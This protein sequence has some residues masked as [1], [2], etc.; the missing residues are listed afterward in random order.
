MAIGPLEILLG[1]V[2]LKRCVFLLTIV[3]AIMAIVCV[4]NGGWHGVDG[5]NPAEWILIIFSMPWF[6]LLALMPFVP[7][8]DAGYF[9]GIIWF[10]IVPLI[11]NSLLI[12]IMVKIFRWVRPRFLGSR[13]KND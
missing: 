3:Y 11:L 2:V 1:D 12:Y 4:F 5:A 9:V 6:F 13:S 10:S 8:P 7:A